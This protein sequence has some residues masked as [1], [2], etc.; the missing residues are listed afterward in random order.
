MQLAITAGANESGN[1]DWQLKDADALQAE[2]A[3]QAL[4]HAR[5]IASTMAAGL[6]AKL[7][8]LLYASNQTP[9]TTPFPNVGRGAGGN[10]LMRNSAPAPL[11]IEPQRIRRS[12]TVYAAFAIE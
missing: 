2:A 4:K 12:A 3:R 7:G 10:L 9:P 8:S 5:E 11:S 1:I 6:G